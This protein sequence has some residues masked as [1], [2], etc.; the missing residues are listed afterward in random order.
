[1]RGSSSVLLLVGILGSLPSAL[2]QSKF[3][4]AGGPSYT[5]PDGVVWEA[6]KYFNTGIANPSSAIIT[7]TNKPTLYQSE[8]YDLGGGP[9]MVYN[10]PIQNGEYD[11]SL[12]FAETYVRSVGAR[13]FDVKMEDTTVF[14]DVDIYL[15]SGRQGNKALVK[16]TPVTVNDGSLTIDF[17]HV[18]ENPSISGIEIHPAATSSGFVTRINVGGNTY[19]DSQGNTWVP[20]N[21]F[22]NTGIQYSVSSSTTITGTQDPT[23]FRSERWDPVSGP[24][25]KFSIPVP[26]GNFEIQLLFAEVYSSAT[27]VGARVFDVKMEGATVFSN[28]D[29]YKDAGNQGGRALIKS[30]TLFVTDGT[31]EIELVRKEQNPKVGSDNSGAG[32]NSQAGAND[33]F[34]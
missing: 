8:R 1:M 6:D 11:V 13:V 19:V 7:G 10:I 12:H 31:L 25:M 32:H 34:P 18:Q 5:D 33:Y 17:L 15:E 28:V 20:D 9:E 27:E 2:A 21:G 14:N 30:T 24:A 23:L 3:I 26:S 22:V 29:I 16:S 4:N